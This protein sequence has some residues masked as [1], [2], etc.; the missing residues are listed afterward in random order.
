MLNWYVLMVRTGRERKA[1]KEIK[2][3]LWNMEEIH[4]F[5]PTKEVLFRQNRKVKKE[6]APLFPGYVFIESVSDQRK[7]LSETY[8]LVRASKELLKVLRYGDSDEIAVRNDE[9]ALLKNLLNR[10]HCIE[11]SV[12]VIVGDMIVV[13]EGPFAGKESVIKTV[14]RHKMQALIELEFMGDMRRVT[15]GLEIIE[16]IS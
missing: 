1:I 4:P 3:T 6:T 8:G 16:K 12:G 10:E 7:F 5:I 15:V 14:N 13:R 2:S 9:C 11:L